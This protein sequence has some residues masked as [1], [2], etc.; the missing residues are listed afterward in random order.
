MASTMVYPSILKE[1]VNKVAEVDRT[2]EVGD[3]D[4]AAKE[5]VED[6]VTEP[7]NQ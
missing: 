4:E 5:A 2:D 6:K 7:P 1:G 3:A